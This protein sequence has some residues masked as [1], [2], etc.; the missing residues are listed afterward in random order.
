[1]CNIALEK[2]DLSSNTIDNEGLSRLSE[3]LAPNRCLETLAIAF[4]KYS[5]EGLFNL[6]RLF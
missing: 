2:L 5:L 4:N 1:M 6:F 3:A